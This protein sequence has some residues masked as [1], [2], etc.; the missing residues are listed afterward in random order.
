MLLAFALISLAAVQAGEGDLE[1]FH[2]CLAS[3]QDAATAGI[4]QASLKEIRQLLDPASSTSS[5]RL[6][7]EKA[8]GADLVRSTLISL[9]DDWLPVAP[10]GRELVTA[11]LELIVADK[12]PWSEVFELQKNLQNHD[13]TSR[14]IELVEA[15]GDESFADQLREDQRNHIEECRTAL[16]A[17]KGQ[18][19]VEIGEAVTRGLLNEETR[20]RLQG[21][22]EPVAPDLVLNFKD[23][24]RHLD[25]VLT[26][27]L[28]IEA[29]RGAVLSARI[30]EIS[31][32]SRKS[33]PGSSEFKTHS[34]IATYWQQPSIWTTPRLLNGLYSSSKT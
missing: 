34:R 18:V 26:Q 17:K 31:T 2:E 30:D 24:R 25:S 16:K 19:L 3:S 11:I 29:E 15:S 1:A 13:S 28:Q 9:N 5:P 7:L 10:E 8:L 20:N 12:L 21:V 22:V 4:L 32:S 27:L 33:R 6:A 23:V 14:V